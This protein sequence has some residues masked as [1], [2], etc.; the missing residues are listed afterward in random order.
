MGFAASG[1]LDVCVMSPSSPRGEGTAKS[2]C[3]TCC[4]TSLGLRCWSTAKMDLAGRHETSWIRKRTRWRWT[5]L[6]VRRIRWRSVDAEFSRSTLLDANA[7]HRTQMDVCGTSC[8]RKRT[9]YLLD[10]AGHGIY[11]LD[12][13][14]RKCWSTDLD[15]LPWPL[16]DMISLWTCPWTSMEVHFGG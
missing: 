11:P 13:A 2:R 9:S 14:G 15:G 10:I 7:G 16:P 5:L 1:L 4:W 12:I 8:I 6:E 3:F